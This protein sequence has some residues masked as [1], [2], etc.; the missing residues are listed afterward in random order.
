M[1][2]INPNLIYHKN[3]QHVLR[4][5][6]TSSLPFMYYQQ[7]LVSHLTF[8]LLIYSTLV[9]NPFYMDSYRHSNQ[10]ISF[11]IMLLSFH[12]YLAQISFDEIIQS[13]M[14]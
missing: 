11:F 9:H 14:S 2:K 4:N 6:I 5:L 12:Q 10:L 8:L 1:Q 13:L 3:F 7:L